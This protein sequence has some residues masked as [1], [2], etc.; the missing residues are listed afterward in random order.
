MNCIF[1]CIFNQDKYV[2]MFY[3][4]LESILIYS[5]ID[6]NTDILVYTSTPFMNMIKQN[7]LFNMN[8]IRFEINDTY[9]NIDTACK[10][11]LDLFTLKSIIN[12]K[13]I[14]YLDRIYLYIFL[15]FIV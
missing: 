12:Y 2:D 3:L 11:R 6:E 14:L 13:K 10:A 5:K 7:Q 9:N 8:K 4:I 1:I 15:Y